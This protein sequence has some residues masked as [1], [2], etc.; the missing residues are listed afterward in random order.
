MA[1]AAA[2]A[3]AGSVATD[4]ARATRAMTLTVFVAVAVDTGVV[5]VVE[6][7][8]TAQVPGASFF[9][10]VLLVLERELLVRVYSL[11]KAHVIH[12]LN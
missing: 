7:G 4:A 1:A 10:C 3:S 8:H 2:V 11:H 5:V 9:V 12:A 6:V